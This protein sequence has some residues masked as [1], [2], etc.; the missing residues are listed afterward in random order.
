MRTVDWLSR[1]NRLQRARSIGTRYGDR[2]FASLAERYPE[3]QFIPEITDPGD[4]TDLARTLEAYFV[5]DLK[6]NLIERWQEIKDYA[7][8]NTC[9]RSRRV[10]SGCIPR[11]VKRPLS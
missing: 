3:G 7:N 8:T 9:G 4:S 6:A 2:S 10:N 11:I 5:S 1:A